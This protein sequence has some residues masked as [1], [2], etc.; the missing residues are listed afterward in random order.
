MKNN[1]RK[2]LPFAN[3]QLPIPLILILIFVSLLTLASLP[4]V[5]IPLVIAM[6][7]CPWFIQRFTINNVGKYQQVCAYVLVTLGLLLSWQMLVIP[8]LP[9]I[10]A[11][12][13]LVA[14]AKTSELKTARDTKLIWL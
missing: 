10:A 1:L 5:F 6:T 13:L 2:K 4:R 11:V 3:S 14:W 9:A 7:I 8:S 12:M